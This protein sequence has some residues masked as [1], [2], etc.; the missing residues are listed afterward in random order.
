MDESCHFNVRNR[1]P[2]HTLGWNMVFP[3]ILW[4]IC[5]ARNE[6]VF[7][8]KHSSPRDILQRAIKEAK[9]AH[10]LLLNHKGPLEAWQVWVTWHP[11]ESDF[12]KLNSDGAIKANSGLGSAGGLFRNHSG[13][14][15]VGYVARI[16]ATNSF[17]AEL[18][19]LREGLRLARNQGFTNITV[20]MDSVAVVQVL[21]RDEGTPMISNG[22]VA[23][24]KLLMSQFRNVKITHIYREGNT[25][26]DFLANM[27]QNAPHGTTVLEAP[28]DDLI[29][30]LQREASGLAYS[31]RR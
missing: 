14:W 3:Y 20:E 4:S 25:C 2:C 7:N 5:R 31:R 18:W 16:G 10:N 15:I 6:V 19:G 9:E 24:C 30:L 17:L 1:R 21:T 11:P 29:E 12:I 28:P 26:P 22:L 8:R 23:D 13:D 27:G